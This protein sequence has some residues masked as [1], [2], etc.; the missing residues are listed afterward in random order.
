MTTFNNEIF[1]AL[2]KLI[3]YFQEKI[4]GKFPPKTEQIF[5]LSFQLL[6]FEKN[7]CRH[8]LIFSVILQTTPFYIFSESY[9][10]KMTAA[11]SSV[12]YKVCVIISVVDNAIFSFILLR[13]KHIPQCETYTMVL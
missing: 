12:L 6:L 3:D 11:F 5:C 1:G 8:V 4:C 7:W 13:N 10:G 9:G 2:V